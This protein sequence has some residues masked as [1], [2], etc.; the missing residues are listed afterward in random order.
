MPHGTIHKRAC[1]KVYSASVR[2]VGKAQSKLS[3]DWR[4]LTS[5]PHMCDLNVLLL[6]SGSWKFTTADIHQCVSL[7]LKMF[8]LYHFYPSASNRYELSF[9]SKRFYLVEQAWIVKLDPLK[10]LSLVEKANVIIQKRTL[11]H[12]HSC[13]GLIIN[14][15]LVQFQQFYP[16]SS[17]FQNSPFCFATQ[18]S[19]NCIP[20][21]Y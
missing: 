4:T 3:H 17:N 19:K 5:W 11:T 13:S 14:M 10:L 2:Q 7:S 16:V 6:F 1:H 21:H 20:L 15:I 18:L 8:F 9:S 12:V